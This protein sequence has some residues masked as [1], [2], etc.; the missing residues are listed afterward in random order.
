[1]VIKS[2]THSQFNQINSLTTSK[3][4]HSH[5]NARKKKELLQILEEGYHQFKKVNDLLRWINPSIQ[6]IIYK[7][8]FSTTTPPTP[9]NRELVPRKPDLFPLEKSLL[10]LEGSILP[11]IPSFP[12]KLSQRTNEDIETYTLFRASQDF[13]DT[14]KMSSIRWIDCHSFT[15]T[16]K[17]IS[18]TLSLNCEGSWYLMNDGDY[19]GDGDY[20]DNNDNNGVGDDFMHEE[21]KPITPP[22]IPLPIPSNLVK[23]FTITKSLLEM[24]LLIKA[25][26][27]YL[28]FNDFYTEFKRHFPNSQQKRI[29]VFV[30][31]ITHQYYQERLVTATIDFSEDQI[32]YNDEH[33]FDISSSSPKKTAL[34]VVDLIIKQERTLCIAAGAAGT[35]TMLRTLNNGSIVMDLS[36]GE[37]PSP[38]SSSSSLYPIHLPHPLGPP[39]IYAGLDYCDSF[40]L[41]EDVLLSFV[42]FESI[43]KCFGNVFPL[44]RFSGVNFIDLRILTL[45]SVTLMLK[46]D[47]NQ[48]LTLSYSTSEEEEGVLMK[49]QSVGDF[50]KGLHEQPISKDFLSKVLLDDLKR[51]GFLFH[52]EEEE[53]GDLLRISNAPIQYPIIRVSV[54]LPLSVM[55]EWDN[56]AGAGSAN[57]SISTS[58]I[59]LP[60]LSAF[61]VMEA[62]RKFNK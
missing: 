15:V 44:K 22:I 52:M 29:S 23:H 18:F 49:T 47:E 46:K 54:M 13:Q 55:I 48:M 58:I 37:T 4:F 21:T 43:K 28:W 51:N 27:F 31:G 11:Q 56:C 25:S 57:E 14:S 6:A 1:M 30:R 5:D 61:G 19:N 59:P 24:A 50:A 7:T 10:L 41:K 33:F 60:T 12:S 35:T 38:S 53:D 40:N 62:V 20:H 17:G 2:I 16:Y 3:R 34:A 39:V 8:T 26:I 45:P 9:L 36:G 32:A 42:L